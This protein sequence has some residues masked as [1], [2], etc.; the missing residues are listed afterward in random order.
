MSNRILL[1]HLP[2]GEQITFEGVGMSKEGKLIISQFLM[3]LMSALLVALILST[4]HKIT[5][6]RSASR[7]GSDE[8]PS[9]SLVKVASESSQRAEMYQTSQRLEIQRLRGANIKKRRRQAEFLIEN[10]PVLAQVIFEE[11]ALEKNPA[12]REFGLYFLAEQSSAFTLDR[13]TDYLSQ[14]PSE[15]VRKMAVRGLQRLAGYHSSEV[16]L[17]RRALC[18]PGLPRK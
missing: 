14:D 18:R 16:V 13:F 5:I 17:S 12:L 9:H 7:F 15:A 1:L 11:C 6:E 3:V 4:K 8:I 10:D 2:L